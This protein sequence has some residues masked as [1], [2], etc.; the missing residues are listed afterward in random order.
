MGF[1]PTSAMPIPVHFEALQLNE[2]DSENGR[3]R[4]VEAAQHLQLISAKPD[5]LYR[6]LRFPIPIS[7]Q[8]WTAAQLSST[9]IITT[10]PKHL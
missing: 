1:A 2:E 8:Q 10:H 9:V 7:S 6:L 5:P 4:L 3:G